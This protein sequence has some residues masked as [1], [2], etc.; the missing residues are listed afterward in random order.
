MQSFIKKYCLPGTIAEFVYKATS[1]IR[2]LSLREIFE[3]TQT[4]KIV[5]F[6]AF[7][8]F[9]TR[10]LKGVKSD[11]KFVRKFEKIGGDGLTLEETDKILKAKAFSIMN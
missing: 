5:G 3:T 1:L 8:S 9:P 4:R 6:D 10:G 11:L 7:G 2:W